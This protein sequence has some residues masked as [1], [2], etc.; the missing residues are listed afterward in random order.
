MSVD[1]CLTAVASSLQLGRRNAGIKALSSTEL[2]TR[3]AADSALVTIEVATPTA[4]DHATTKQYVDNLVNG[5]QWKNPAR[6]CSG[7]SNITIASPGAT[8]DGTAMAVDDRVLLLDQ[9]VTTENGLW[10]WNG[11]AVP[12]TRPADYASGS[13][14]PAAAVFVEEGT[15]ADNAYVATADPNEVDVNSPGF[16][17]FGTIAPGVTSV[18]DAVAVPSG[19]ASFIASGGSG[20]VTL[21]VLDD[22]P[23]ISVTLASS[24][25]TL[26]IIAASIDTTRLA[27]QAVTIAKLAPNVTIACLTG[28]IA[29]GDAGTTVNIG[30]LPANSQVVNS[31]VD[32][33]T[34]FNDATMTVD[35]Q[36]NAV[37]VQGTL[38]SD[39]NAADQ[40]RCA[41]NEANAAAVS[42]DA[43]VSS[44]TATVGAADI[45]VYYRVT[46]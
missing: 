25:I 38:E 11:A 14:Q 19:G 17:L 4:N 23:R 36:V 12:L 9:T 31:E 3:N 37:S 8:I 20:A 10:V 29:F 41:A 39:L 30:T 33:G 45:C 15:C 44:G 26:D 6:V 42:V 13:F 34:P 35:V 28:S 21:N 40:Y 7:G 46:A 27:N 5:N 24:V 32:V 43:V 16:T 18:N 2:A 1:F 22:S